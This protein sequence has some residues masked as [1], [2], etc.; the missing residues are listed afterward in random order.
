MSAVQQMLMGAG[1]GATDPYYANVSLLLHMDGTNGSTTFTDNSSSPKTITVNNDAQITTTDP[2]FGSGSAIFDGAGDHLN[3]PS[4][5]AFN[6]PGV[7]FT[8]ECWIN[9]ANTTQSGVGLFGE[10]ISNAVYTPFEIQISTTGVAWLIGNASLTNWNS[11]SASVKS[12][13]SANTWNHIALVGDGANITL[14]V[15]GTSRLTV[16]QPNWT[17]AN[18]TVYIGAG[19]DGAFTGKI[20][21]LRVTKGVAR[22]T[23][24]FT[25]PTE[26]FPNS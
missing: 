8:V 2:K 26:A 3:T 21:E 22:Y 12:L 24:N 11:T 5:N 16:S 1:G 17:S 14:Y 23:S 6:F 7:S 10:R 9:P 25:P 4:D 20:D 19:G 18:R 15:N 13:F